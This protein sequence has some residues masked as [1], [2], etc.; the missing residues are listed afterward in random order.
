MKTLTDI[1]VV[2]RDPLAEKSKGG[3]YFPESVLKNE[4]KGIYLGTILVAGP[5]CKVL[6]VGDRVA[7]ARSTY[8]LYTCDEYGEV[9]GLHESDVLYALNPE[10]P[11]QEPNV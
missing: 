6:K 1:V 7:F 10:D 9:C 8:V 3:I 11:V 5:D 4:E 2:K